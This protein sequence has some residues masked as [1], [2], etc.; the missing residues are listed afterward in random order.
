MTPED[1]VIQHCTSLKD[2]LL[3]APDGQISEGLKERIKKWQVPFIPQEILH[4]IWYAQYGAD[5]SDFVF[6]VLRAEL[7]SAY[8]RGGYTEEQRESIFK[9][10]LEEFQ[11]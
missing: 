9:K 11:I 8:D 1:R 7:D 3:K 4:T 10:A 5:A 2:L 6:A